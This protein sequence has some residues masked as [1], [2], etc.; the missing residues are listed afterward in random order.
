MIIRAL[1]ATEFDEHADLVYVSYSHE[2]ELEPGSMLTHRDW[3]LRGIEREPYYEPDQTR[4]MEVDGRLVASV[5]CYYRPTWVHGRRV[6]AACIGS[7]CTHPDY[8]RRGYVRR[9]LAEAVEWMRA[10]GWE[11]SFLYGL[12]A[13]YGGSGWRNLTTFEVIADV[14]L[15]DDLELQTRERPIDPADDEDIAALMRIYDDFCAPLAG[16]TIRTEQYWRRRVLASTPW[17]R[18][19][20]YRF[21][22]HEGEPCGY[23]YIDGSAVREVG[24]A[25]DPHPVLAAIFSHADGGPVS[26]PLIRPEL[27]TALREVAAIPT[28]SES[29]ERA[30][31]ITLRAAYRGLWRHHGISDPAFP[32]VTDTAG[33]VRM[34]HDSD[35]VMWPIDRA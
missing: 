28:Q 33:L 3:W 22:L 14:T 27:L 1:E 2:R 23:Y 34:L 4:V 10:R 5:T 18:A 24:W 19:P 35:Y 15:R 7:V 9:L 11:W 16:A 30:D 26:F 17:G 29:F 21:V 25:G 32:G 31:S 13:V 12:E 8:R 6:E 20:E